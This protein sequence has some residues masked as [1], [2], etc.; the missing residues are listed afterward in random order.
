M[1]ASDNNAALLWDA[2]NGKSIAEPMKHKNRLRSALF[3]P[4]G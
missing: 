3:S 4:D 2:A 1:A